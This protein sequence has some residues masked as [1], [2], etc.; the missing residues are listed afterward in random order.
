[1]RQKRSQIKS[2]LDEVKECLARSLRTKQTDSPTTQ[3]DMGDWQVE[4]RQPRS[5]SPARSP[6]PSTKAT[7]EAGAKVGGHIQWEQV[8]SPYQ[9]FRVGTHEG[10]PENKPPAQ[11]S[12]SSSRRTPKSRRFQLSAKEEEMLKRA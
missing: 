11:R 1:M 3:Q 10:E 7:R 5:Q 6:S 2:E 4:A 12:S 8:V 9:P